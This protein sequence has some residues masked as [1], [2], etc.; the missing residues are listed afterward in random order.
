MNDKVFLDAFYWLMM[1]HD[2]VLYSS[3][4][5]IFIMTVISLIMILKRW[6]GSY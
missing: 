6:G 4:F 2:F 5:F 3:G 1:N